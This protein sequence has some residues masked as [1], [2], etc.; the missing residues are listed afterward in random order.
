MAFSSGE[1]LA[2]CLQE[3]MTGEKN[4]EYASP[5]TWTLTLSGWRP[6]TRRK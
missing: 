6:G 5:A 3:P 1:P 2:D 4:L